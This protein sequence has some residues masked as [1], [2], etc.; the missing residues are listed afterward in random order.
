M[1]A[2]GA[3]AAAPAH[4]DTVAGWALASPDARVAGGSVRV[5]TLDGKQLLEKPVLTSQRGTFGVRVD[6]LPKRFVVTVTGGRAGSTPVRGRL[7]LIANRSDGGMLHVTPMSTLVAE[8]H[9]RHGS[10]T[11]AHREVRRYLALPPAWASHAAARRDAAS[12]DGVRFLEQASRAGGIAA[13]ARQL[14]DRVTGRPQPM[15]VRPAAKRLQDEAA[16]ADAAL[17]ATAAVEAGSPNA[18]L[19]NLANGAAQQVGF[20]AMGSVLSGLGLGHASDLSEIRA[21][22]KQLQAD[23]DLLNARVAAV[24]QTLKDVQSELAESTYATLDSNLGVSYI[25]SEEDEILSDLT[26][27]VDHG[28]CDQASADCGAPVPTGVDPLAWC[29]S[30]L[31]Q[32]SPRQATAC[33]AMRRIQTLVYGDDYEDYDERLLGAPNVPLGVL[34]AYQRSASAKIVKDGGFI[35]PAYRDGVLAVN[36]HYA[37]ISA[38]MATYEVQ[39]NRAVGLPNDLIGRGIKSAQDSVARQA[40]VVPPTL[41]PNT[42]IDTKTNRTWRLQENTHTSCGSR[43]S[44]WGWLS[45]TSDQWTNPLAQGA[46]QMHWMLETV[47]TGG[48]GGV[49]L[50]PSVADLSTAL[51]DWGAASGLKNADGTRR[52]PTVAAWMHEGDWGMADLSSLAS[53]PVPPPKVSGLPANQQGGQFERNPGTAFGLATSECEDLNWASGMYVRT[54]DGGASPIFSHSRFCKY[55]RLADARVTKQCIHVVGNYYPCWMPVRKGAGDG[56]IDYG[57]RLARLEWRPSSPNEGYYSAS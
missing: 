14:G 30:G 12:F 28:E 57:H 48:H 15:R 26:W 53:L 24:Q 52:Y 54:S 56:P 25:G 42:V 37:W 29:S 46:C 33:D 13:Y 39:Y 11:R 40:A 4:A 5:Q 20:T 50:A 44:R 43:E 35:T 23:F 45:L 36:A 8:R 10:L 6:Q 55:V 17:E 49:W 34:Q 3:G 41:P 19:T 7:R 51:R 22:L 21:E 27:I 18:L 31:E 9:A 16:E 1:V 47:N 32:K 2:A 38:L